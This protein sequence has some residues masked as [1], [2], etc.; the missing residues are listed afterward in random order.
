MQSKEITKNELLLKNWTIVNSTEF[1]NQRN[2]EVHVFHHK[3]ITV[4]VEGINK[5]NIIIRGKYPN[6]DYFANTTISNLEE[7]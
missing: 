6:D 1:E 4:Q 3:E 2:N 5:K 7:V